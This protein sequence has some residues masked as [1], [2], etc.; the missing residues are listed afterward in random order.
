[1][2]GPVAFIVRTSAVLFAKPGLILYILLYMKYNVIFEM[3]K[4]FFERQ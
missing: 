3:F 2:E 1:M 4:V